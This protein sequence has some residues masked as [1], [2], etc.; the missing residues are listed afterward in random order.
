MQKPRP[1]RPRFSQQENRRGKNEKDKFNRLTLSY[2]E[3]VKKKC[4]KILSSCE[5][6]GMPRRALTR[7]KTGNRRFILWAFPVRFCGGGL[8]CH[9]EAGMQ[10]GNDER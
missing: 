1:F 5:V 2:P 8:P 10:A 9:F 3:F 6:A 7:G 4:A